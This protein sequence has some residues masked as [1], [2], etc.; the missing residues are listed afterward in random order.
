MV[1]PD[2]CKAISDALSAETSLNGAPPSPGHVYLP[3]SHYRAL[4][5]ECSI[6]V[7]MRGAGKSFWSS[8]LTDG[9]VKST[10]THYAP[11]SAYKKVDVVAGY[12]EVPNINRYPDRDVFEQLLKFGFEPLLVWKAITAR[13]IADRTQNNIPM[14]MWKETISW[15]K[16]NP[17]KYSVL[18]HNFNLSLKNEDKRLL[19]LFDALDRTSDKWPIM[20]QVVRDLFRFQLSLKPYSNILT[21]S[22][23]RNDQVEN[24]NVFDFPDASKLMSSRVDLSWSSMDLHGLLWQYLLNPISSD[25]KN[26]NNLFTSIFRD[27]NIDVKRDS[28]IMSIPVPELFRKDESIQRKVFTVLAGEWMGNDPRRGIPYTWIVN[29][30]ADSNGRV[31]PRSFLAAIRE[32][33]LDSYDRYK[34][35]KYPLHYESIKRGVQSASQIRVNEL[36][37]EDYPWVKKIMSPLAG[38][39]VPCPF[40]HIENQWKKSRL[41]SDKAFVN[42]KLPPE[43]LGNPAESI[44]KT[45]SMLG[46]FEVAKDHRI[47]MPDLYRVGF[48]LGRK[49]G[50]VPSARR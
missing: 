11:L 30:L 26:P 33:A 45:L 36:V 40:I 43:L 23:V 15:V 47:N 42:E 37:S 44:C 32:A 8:A 20:D 17:E 25:T 50:I 18:L 27:Q 2:I 13:I 12:S 22:F 19:I 46:I 4:N 6:V 48:G 7:G 9:S 14:S 21:K 5:L 38:L 41:L 28:K 24:R 10:L 29:H 49:G 3:T 39:N 34:E 16:E 1:N 31:S 35:H